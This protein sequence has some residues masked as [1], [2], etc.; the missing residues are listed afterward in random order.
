[1]LML[2]NASLFEKKAVGVMRTAQKK[3]QQMATRI[4]DLGFRLWKE[5]RILDLAVQSNCRIFVRECCREAIDARMY[6]DIDPYQNSPLSFGS[7]RAFWWILFNVFPFFGLWAAMAPQVGKDELFLIYSLFPK[8]EGW[9][10]R[11]KIPPAKEVVRNSTQRR[12]NPPPPEEP[13]EGR[14]SKPDLALLWDPT[15]TPMER[16]VLFWKAPIVIFI[17]NAIVALTVTIIF[18]EH[19][20]RQSPMNQSLKQ[21]GQPVSWQD[22]VIM[23]YCEK[24]YFASCHVPAPMLTCA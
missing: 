18:S 4:L 24:K 22:I 20:I 23:V 3:D 10:I 13:G 15:F 17:F 11:F 2:E 14:Q 8:L 19:F 16:F 5:T 9:A 21:F 1:M 7:M 12:L 6:G